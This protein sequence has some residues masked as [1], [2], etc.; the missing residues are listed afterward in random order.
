MTDIDVLENR[1]TNV[2]KL[3]LEDNSRDD[4]AHK[5]IMDVTKSAISEIKAMRK[6]M[7]DKFTHI[8]K[9]FE[10]MPKSFVT[11]AEA[12]IVWSLVAAFVWFAWRLIWNKF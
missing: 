11:K 9:K 6:E 2:E 12:R 3:R 4:D 8:D 5:A 1:V 7:N 10:K